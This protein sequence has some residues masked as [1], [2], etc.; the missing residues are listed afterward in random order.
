MGVYVVMQLR[1]TIAPPTIA[2]RSADGL[3]SADDAST[4]VEGCCD[5][6]KIVLTN[7]R[8]A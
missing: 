7:Q 6:D 8:T 3:L 5:G 2:M 1:I 4:L